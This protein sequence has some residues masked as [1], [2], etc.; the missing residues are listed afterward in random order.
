MEPRYTV[1]VL[2]HSIE[3]KN[4]F[5][6]LTGVNVSTA[7]KHPIKQAPFNQREK[8]KNERSFLLTFLRNGQLAKEKERASEIEREERERECVVCVCCVCERG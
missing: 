4:M 2:S 3:W 6:L 1:P 7:D 5:K 8:H